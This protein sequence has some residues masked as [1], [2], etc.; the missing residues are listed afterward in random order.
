MNTVWKAPR[1]V[2]VYIMAAVAALLFLAACGTREVVKEVPVEVVVK[3]E[4]IKEVQIPGET[5]VVEKEVVKEVK[6]PVEVVV[7]KEVVKEI[8][9]ERLVEKE[10]IKEVRV[11]GETVVVEKEVIKE[12]QVPGETVVVEKEVIKEVQVPGETVVVEK[13]VV[14]EVQVP[15]E[16]VVVTKEVVKEVEVEV[17]VEKEV[18]KEVPK[19]I[20]VTKE[21]IKEVEKIVEVAR[22]AEEKVLRVRMANMPASFTPHTGG[23]GAVTITLGW[24]FSRLVQ[25]GPATGSWAPDLAAGWEVNEDATE[26]TF[27]LQK[28]AK[29]HD[30]TPVT[31]NDVAFTIRSLLHPQS[32]EWMVNTYISVK[33]A[34]AYQEGNAMDVEGIQVVDDHT[35]KLTMERPNV[36]F[37]DELVT[38]AALSPAPILPEHALKDIPDDQLFEHDFWSQG[39][40][41]S[42]PFKFVS[43]VP[44][45][46][47]VLEAFDDFYFGR[48]NVDRLILEIIPSADA[49]QIALQRGEVD[50]TVR[51]GV[52]QAANREFLQDPRFDVYGTQAGL[53]R[54]YA[55]NQRI[56]RLRDP[57]IREAFWIGVDWQKICDQ[58]YGG[59]CNVKGSPLFQSFV[60][61]PEWDAR[62]AYNPS[63]A[64]SLME[65]AGYSVSNPIDITMITR[66]ITNPDSRAQYAVQQD[67]LK[68]VG[69]NFVIKEQDTAAGQSA[70]YDTYE[71]EVIGW[72]AG[73][74]S[75]PGVFLL[76]NLGLTGGENAF[77]IH[78]QYPD[79][80]AAMEEG[81]AIVDR[82]ERAKFFQ[83]F[84][85][86]WLWDVLPWT[87]I[88]EAANVKIQNNRFR[89]PI[90]GDVPKVSK[91]SDM[92]IY[93]VH[94]GRD[95]NWIYHMEQWDIRQ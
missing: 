23:S 43:W 41:G 82:G 55:W 1:M 36:T 16:T 38:I 27:Y 21:V 94:S 76:S 83:N 46:A 40:M 49:T 26:Y 4:V 67:M 71:A 72:A 19:E 92:P 74:M 39:L 29:W 56:E 3:E 70:W 33:G 79:F 59:L 12:V 60:Y 30:G 5:I 32:A 44:Q 24:T 11:P 66:P 77:G 9:V 2:L 53:I 50:T 65:A 54:S 91:Y 80:Y 52:S 84:T 28:H 58:F 31:A 8:P 25:P 34:K 75:E 93:P 14:K 22:P 42:G 45:Q 57:R 35:I 20:V 7:E 37:L 47:M 62:F 64:M 69:I 51:G 15:G 17:V 89:M 63:K 81:A 95:D 73:S 48:P 87:S 88:W 18:V 78:H 13:E 90:L 68:D 86:T 85:E 10:V 6:V 61:K